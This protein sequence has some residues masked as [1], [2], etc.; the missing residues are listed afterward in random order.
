MALVVP[1]VDFTDFHSSLAD[2][3]RTPVSS[4][5]VGRPR[6]LAFRLPD[7]RG[8]TYRFADGVVTFEMSVADDAA[9]II[10][11]D[12]AAFA[13]FATE[14]LTA[15]GLQIQQM[16][17]YAAGGF[18]AFDAWE[19]LLRH[20]YAGRPVYDPAALDGVDLTVEFEWGVDSLDDISA[21]F[22]LT[23][24]AVVR[25]V[26]SPDEA[27]ALDVELDRLAAVA[28]P[29]DGD[30]WWVT[31]ADGEDRVCQLHYTSLGS[32]LIE[33]LESDP[34]VRALV[35]CTGDGYVPH[36]TTGNGHFAVLK[37]PGVTGGLTDLAWHVDCG[38]GGHPVTCP[39]MHL[40]VQVRAMSAET[41]EM[42]FL[43]GS[44][45][46][47]ARRPTAS[48][49]ASWPVVRVNAE[50]GDVTLHSPDSMHAA[51][52]PSG[53]SEGRR[54]IYLSFGAPDLNRIFGFKDGYDRM[55]FKGDGR[56]E[57]DASDNH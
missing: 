9:T 24:F 21:Y 14:Y 40:G 17:H 6:P 45:L 56:V 34:R 49:E 44:H 41:G 42:C 51:P 32:T 50:P 5:W 36:P 39:S 33:S 26:F 20:L 37:N 12:E 54:T 19:P 13:A 18:E 23:G 57:F 1:R 38:L 52:P 15:P 4:Q 48:E 10:E 47:S 29:N 53:E 8:V 28:D 35:D 46:T 43:A 11:L 7:G 16:V 22:R 25:K 3:A 55:L 2:A 27:A 30:S 31:G